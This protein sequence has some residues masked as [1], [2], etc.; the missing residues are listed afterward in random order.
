VPAGVT[1]AFHAVA[2]YDNDV[3]WDVTDDATWQVVPEGQAEIEG[4][5]LTIDP[6]NVGAELT[7]VATYTEQ[8]VTLT[9]EKDVLALDP[10][11]TV[12]D[13]W[14]MYQGNRR[15]TGYVPVHLDPA[16]FS[17]RW[18]RQLSEHPLNPVTA[19]DGRV[20]ASIQIYFDDEP[21]LFALDAFTGQ[22][23]WTRGF[24]SVFSV[25]PPSCAYGNV[26]V[27]SG[28][29][30]DDTY[31]WAFD[32]ASGDLVFQAPHAA[33][34]ER[35]YAPTIYDGAVYVNGGTYGGMYGFDAF[36]GGQRWFHSLPQY[37][38]WTPAVEGDSAYAYVGGQLFVVDRHTGNAQYAITDPD[39]DWHGWSM[40]LAPVLGGQDDVL[41]I[42]NGRLVSFDLVQR[43][44]RWQQVGGFSGQPSVAEGRV[45]AIRFGDLYV[46][47]Q[48]TGA[49]LWYW[50]PPTGNLSG[51]LVVTASHV[52]VT[53][54]TTTYAI[55]RLEHNAAWS[56]PTGGAL[57]FGDEVLYI[58]GATGALT[59]ISMPESIP[60]PVVGLE[61]T[62]PSQV[63]ENSI[64]RY[65]AIATYKNGRTS[66]RTL[67]VEW[68]V[69]P[70]TFAAFSQPGLLATTE[71]TTLSLPVTIQGT[72]EENGV[73]V[74]DELE[75]KLVIGVSVEEFLTRSL[76]HAI[77][78]EAEAAEALNRMLVHE[79]ASREALEELNEPGVAPWLEQAIELT[80]Q[81]RHEAEM[82]R[83]L[84]QKILERSPTSHGQPGPPSQG[85]REL[86]TV[87]RPPL[88]RPGRRG[89]RPGRAAG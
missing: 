88:R 54:G 44:V 69:S 34:W 40:D 62:G 84:L 22:T 18:Q 82:A 48:A 20:F 49:T 4:G 75:V 3:E 61:L 41:T 89:R 45:F 42:E 76:E 2:K 9:A 5:E 64:T 16:T 65:N 38:E 8:G 73:I 83:D 67:L 36:G 53:T 59:A 32:A 70:A 60:S 27:Q 28:N 66:D 43:S 7:V 14:T 52:L 85:S 19:V 24:G 87:R 29:H 77:A 51:T 79:L 39:F 25:N 63:V 33:Q 86:L 74:R 13:S 55:D 1:V 35:Y 56:Y 11:D 50:T 47:D 46:L 72:Y 12:T 23:L 15:H 81:A 30:G 57:A 17:P 26:Y 10:D 58:A 21:Q 80:R 31:L 37:D 71:M 6:D 68:S 78:H